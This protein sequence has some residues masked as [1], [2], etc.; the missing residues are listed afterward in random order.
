MDLSVGGKKIIVVAGP[1]GSGKTSF[2]DSFLTKLDI[3]FLNPDLI[4]SG[5][6]PSSFEASSFQAGRILLT[7]I[8]RRIHKGESFAFE[9][10]LSGLTYLNLLGNAKI[11]GYQISIYFVCLDSIT[12]NIERIEKRVS[13]GGH[14]IPT[15]I[16]RRR[17]LK[18][19][20][21][22]WNLYKDLAH[23]WSIIEN[24]G[25]K[26]TFVLNSDTYRDLD[27]KQKRTFEK[28]F[29]RARIL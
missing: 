20:S 8:K 17:H 10:T 23:E 2:A 7:D 1:N 5:L 16:V 22:F 15:A 26:P 14:N 28:R 3:S 19:F 25:T 4:A 29:L 18:C 11:A 27:L 12:R 13:Q 21:N 24:T 6:G 9:S